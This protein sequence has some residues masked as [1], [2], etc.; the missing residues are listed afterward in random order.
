MI[1]IAYSRLKN[2]KQVNAVSVLVLIV[3]FDVYHFWLSDYRQLL[4]G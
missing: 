3:S 2:L 1:L 4:S